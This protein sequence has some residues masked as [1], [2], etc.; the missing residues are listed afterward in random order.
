M[1]YEETSITTD[2][3][4]R[5]RARLNRDGMRI[6][7]LVAVAGSVVLLFYGLFLSD[8]GLNQI[9]DD[10]IGYGITIGTS[11]VYL[12]VA[13]IS[14]LKHRWVNGMAYAYIAV[15]IPG[16]GWLAG[17]GHAVNLPVF[18]FGM[19]LLLTLFSA[20]RIQY[21][22]AIAYAAILT[23]VSA[24][25]GGHWPFHFADWVIL[26]GV[27][28]AMF[29]FLHRFEGLRRENLELQ[30]RLQRESLKDALTGV[31]NR[32]FFEE[33]LNRSVYQQQRGPL[34][35][36][37]AFLDIDGYKRILGQYGD[38]EGE[39][40]MRKVSGLLKASFREVDVLARYDSDQFGLVLHGVE[41]GNLKRIFTRFRTQ[42]ANLNSDPIPG[43]VTVSVGVTSFRDG[44]SVETITERASAYMEMA[45]EKGSDSVVADGWRL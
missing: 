45:L 2:Q 25:I 8:Q 32:K 23:V 11:L 13:G 18:A 37:L 12:L 33:S 38:F 15:F 35:F 40:L 39:R 5:E 1:E 3:E 19:L 31:Y 7:A 28:V 10:L 4:R 41:E 43:P 21:A 6:F 24:A 22:L 42:L 16:V 14:E 29:W 44:D 26:V 9:A 27:S 30:V 20:P 34:P 17:A 36:A